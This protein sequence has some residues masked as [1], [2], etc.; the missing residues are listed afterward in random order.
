MSVSPENSPHDRA[1]RTLVK[2]FTFAGAIL[3]IGAYGLA[4]TVV[5]LGAELDWFSLAPS[6]GKAWWWLLAGAGIGLCLGLVLVQL[7]RGRR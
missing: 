1:G 3:G 7:G 5:L 6:V 4:R 2:A